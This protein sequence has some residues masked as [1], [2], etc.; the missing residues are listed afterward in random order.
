MALR[1]GYST[2]GFNLFRCYTEIDWVL[3]F[4]RDAKLQYIEEL[5]AKLGKKYNVVKDVTTASPDSMAKS[6]SPHIVKDANG[7]PLS[8]MYSEF[9]VPGVFDW[10]YLNALTQEQKDYVMSID[11]FVDVFHDPRKSCETQAKTLA[12]FKML[13]IQDKLHLLN[14]VDGFVDWY[15]EFRVPIN[16]KLDE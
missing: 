16:I 9:G 5:T 12:I 2:D 7:N 10:L 8:D 3:G 11:C 14:D 1:C 15:N 6:L 4:D 13:C